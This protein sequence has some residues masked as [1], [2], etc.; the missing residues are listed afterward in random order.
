MQYKFD[1]GEMDGCQDKL[2]L[3]AKRI[4]DKSAICELEK[5][6]RDEC[7]K[8]IMVTS[9]QAQ[10]LQN[11]IMEEEEKRTRKKRLAMTF[12]QMVDMC[13]A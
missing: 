6:D 10:E 7:C 9:L 4:Q 8:P 5:L 1:A 13:A 11:Q 2:Q 3:F 12:N